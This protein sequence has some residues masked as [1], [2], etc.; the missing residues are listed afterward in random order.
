MQGPIQ[1]IT[2][3]T[4]TPMKIGKGRSV[5]PFVTVVEE[6]GKYHIHLLVFLHSAVPDDTEIGIGKVMNDSITI[7]I[8]PEKA[9]KSDITSSTQNLWSILFELT[10]EN[11]SGKEIEVIVNFN[12]GGLGEPKRGTKVIIA[13]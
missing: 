13:E 8:S 3:R 6:D 9:S 1:R 12:E 5:G 10:D 11:L 4:I 7:T 2:D